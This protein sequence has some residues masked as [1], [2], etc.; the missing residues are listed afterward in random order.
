MKDNSAI[1]SFGNDF[2]SELK[3]L[4]KSYKD[5]NI[6]VFDPYKIVII[7]LNIDLVPQGIKVNERLF[8]KLS[9]D[10]ITKLITYL[11]K[12]FSQEILRYF[13]RIASDIF[14][15]FNKIRDQVPAE[16][17]AGMED[18]VIKNLILSN[19]KATLVSAQSIKNFIVIK[20]N[21]TL[22]DF[23]IFINS[24]NIVSLPIFK[25]EIVSVLIDFYVRYLLTLK[26]QKKVVVNK[27]TSS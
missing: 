12:R 25:K 21:G 2:F 20:T 8:A 16:V 23:Q 3:K 11:T 6:Y 14:N 26:Q 7:K 24:Q 15:I 22:D 18:E 19:L 4:I 1:N 9:V 10:D 5:E 17:I 13:D 27:L